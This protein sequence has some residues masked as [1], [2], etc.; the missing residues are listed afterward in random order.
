MR[1]AALY[2]IHGNL[3]ALDAVLAEIRAERID[4]IMVGGDV[5]PGPMPGETLERLSQ[6]EMPVHFI[7]GNGETDVLTCLAG[8]EPERVP[9]AHRAPIRWCAGQLTPAQATTIAAWPLTYGMSHPVLGE[10][11]FCHATPRSDNEIITRNTP[12]AALTGWLEEEDASIV[13][14]GHTHM[15]FDRRVGRHRIVNAGSVGMPFGEPGAWWLLLDRE[16]ELQHTKYD[17]EA[18]A[19]RIAGTDFPG[20]LEFA[21]N[22]VVQPPAAG[23]MQALFDRANAGPRER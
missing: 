2:D 16:V 17:L 8:R 13:V 15:Q 11:L 14:C 1:I 3:P 12:D 19:G 18:A 20:C 7:H 23:M 4:R 6:L 22:N 10:I 21:R 5:L 9:E